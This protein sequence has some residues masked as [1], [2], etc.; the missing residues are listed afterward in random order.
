MQPKIRTLQQTLIFLAR[1]A[2]QKKLGA[3]G[4]QGGCVYADLATGQRCAIGALLTEDEIKTLGTLATRGS[5]SLSCISGQLGEDFILR[6]GLTQDLARALQDL[7]D[8]TT[9]F[10]N[11]RAFASE[12]RN[13]AFYAPQGGPIVLKHLKVALDQ[14]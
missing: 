10:D 6:N 5:I 7:H 13:V 1:Q 3:Q 9:S 8:H 2:E 14:Y 12:L 4:L 11:L